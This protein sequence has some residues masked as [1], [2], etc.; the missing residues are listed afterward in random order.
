MCGI[1]VLG[2]NPGGEQ[3]SL[4]RVE[5]AS[6]GSAQF[7]D[8]AVEICWDEFVRIFRAKFVPEHIQDKMEQVFLSLTEGSMTVLEYEARVDTMVQNK[9]RNVKK[10][11]SS[12]DT[13]P[14]QV[15]TKGRQVD[16]R[17]PSQKACFAV[18][19]SRSTLDHLRS[20][21]ETSPRELFCQSGT[22]CRHTSRA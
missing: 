2:L 19:N 12:V 7:E 16:T 15:D 20:T 10:R 4:V 18:W 6:P 14:G 3:V 8:G 17:E 1:Q 11:S 5:S 13:S 21:L 22:V 9:G